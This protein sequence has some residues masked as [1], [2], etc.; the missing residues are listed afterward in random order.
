MKKLLLSLG[1]WLGL[2]IS[3]F[4]Q[5]PQCPT[6]PLNDNT[7]A[8]A[9]T[10]FV[11][12]Q[13]ATPSLPLP[14]TQIYVGN[15]QGFAT[16]VAMSGDTNISNTGAVTIQPGAVTGPKIA[17]NA[18][19]NS[20]LVTGAANTY[21]GSLNGTTTSDITLTACTL[22]YQITQY[23][24]GTGWQCGIIPVLP[25][26]ATA[27]TLN[28]S[29][30]SSVITLGYATPG[31]GGGATFKNAGS[32]AFIDTYIATATIAGGSGYTAGT[33]NGVAL[34]G[35]HGSTCNVAIVVSGGAVTSVGNATYCPGY[36]VGDVLTA[37]NTFI[38]GTGSGFSWTVTAISTQQGSFIDS[39]STH[40]QVIAD[41]AIVSA[42]QFGC[43]GDWAG[44]GTD[45]T[46]TNNAACLWSALSFVS[47]N[48]NGQLSQAG[49]GGHLIVPKGA[50]M[51]CGAWNGTAWNIPVPNSVRVSGDSIFG[52]V[53]A[54]CAADNP[55]STYYIE[56]CDANAGSGQFGCKI[57]N[58]TLYLFQPTGAS[59]L[60][61][62]FSSSGQQFALAENVEIDAKNRG[63]VSYQTGTGGAANDIWIGIDC[64]QASTA[65][66]AGFLF[67]ASG[68]QHILERS[69][70]ASGPAGSVICIQNLNGRLIASGIDIEGY[71]IGLD[72]NVTTA[73]NISSYKNVQEQS[74]GCTAAIKLESTNA[75]NNI[76]I[77]N[78][79]T[80]CPTTVQNVPSGVNTT[81]NILKQVLC[82][83]AGAC[84]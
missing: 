32:A 52:T 23:I 62:I 56:L 22:A 73:G 36:S 46:S 50:Y 13:F 25:S 3:A 58:I 30:F 60:A 37:S 66:T 61:A 42:L 70:C 9:S 71:V 83:A 16:A 74:G 15:V 35:G 19:A 54:E 82:P 47:T 24:L 5:N 68:A 64:V 75:A 55:A 41:H 59:T 18:V 31:D 43:K 45:G 26:R 72:Q 21:K 63:C 6:R 79:A 1:L 20:N 77:E 28:L 67:N 2:T 38:G 17:T 14:N 48:N 80:G 65:T 69:V 8:C 7:N 84:S 78:I 44:V 4:A 33:Y 57:E 10:A 76:L 39:V 27:A 53:L 49:V 11:Q 12:Q 40:W 29:A 34:T 51:T 81:G